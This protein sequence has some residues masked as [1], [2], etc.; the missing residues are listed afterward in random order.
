M[1]VVSLL[2]WPDEKTKVFRS[3][4]IDRWHCLRKR[5]DGCLKKE[6]IISLR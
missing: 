4:T 2:K 5:E 3:Q 6:I 1:E